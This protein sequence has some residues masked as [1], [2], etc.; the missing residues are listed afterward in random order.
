MTYPELMTDLK[1]RMKQH[2]IAREKY[3]L[4]V[5]RGL[6]AALQN[7]E[8]ELLGVDMTEDDVM[9]IILRE[10]KQYKEALEG[11]QQSERELLIAEAQ[12][13]LGYIE[14]FLPKPLTEA[15]VID[16][17]NTITH[18]VQAAKPRDIGKVM[19]VLMSRIKGK[20]DGKRAKEL[21]MDVLDQHQV[22]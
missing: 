17:I 11:A 14:Q 21:V 6:I 22:V 13:K 19:P 7:R 20:F 16:M 2:M 3:F 10:T 15:D 12:T 5:V 8:K 4:D 18:E 9:T 1:Q